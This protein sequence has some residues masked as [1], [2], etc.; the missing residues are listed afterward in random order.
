MLFVAAIEIRVAFKNQ[1][2]GCNNNIIIGFA[3]GT[4]VKQT[5]NGNVF[6]HTV[7][8]QWTILY[9]CEFPV[10]FCIANS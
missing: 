9:H 6:S 7:I 4:G 10:A 2:C 3:W 8:T 1:C 5:L